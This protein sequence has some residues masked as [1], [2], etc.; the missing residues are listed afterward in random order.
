MVA[1]TK[2][3]GKPGRR[4]KCTTTEEDEAE[5]APGAA[6][7]PD[8]EAIAT[9]KSTSEKIAELLASGEWVPA[10]TSPFSMG[11]EEVQ[12]GSVLALADAGP[13]QEK[14]QTLGLLCLFLT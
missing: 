3:K 1:A 12:D 13:A 5:S 8:M 4:S 2:T 9:W 14:R 6:E 10:G 7:Q 11:M